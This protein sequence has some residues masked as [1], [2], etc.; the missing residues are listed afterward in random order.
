MG[1]DPRQL[2]LDLRR[3]AV[4]LKRLGPDLRRL[5]LGPRLAEL[6]PI[7]LAID[8]LSEGVGWKQSPTGCSLELLGQ[9]MVWVKNLQHQTLLELKIG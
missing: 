7:Q 2:G 4:D 5:V 8:Y 1:L 3:L 9:R 6:D